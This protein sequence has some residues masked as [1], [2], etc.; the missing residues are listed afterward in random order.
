LDDD[1]VLYIRGEG[2]P[3]LVSEE[4]TQLA[5]QLVAAIGKQPLAAP[6][7]AEMTP[8][9]SANISTEARVRC[10]FAFNG[11]ARTTGPIAAANGITSCPFVWS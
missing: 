8:M 2:D 3:F 5:A 7:A 6:T 1:R 4:L 11:W 9:Q 10:Q